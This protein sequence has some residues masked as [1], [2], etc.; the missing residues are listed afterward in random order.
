[1]GIVL[2]V[3]KPPHQPE[4][5]LIAALPPEA[6][7][8]IDAEPRLVS[9]RYDMLLV[10][11]RGLVVR[12]HVSGDYHGVPWAGFSLDAHLRRHSRHAVLTLWLDSRRPVELAINMGLASNIAAVA[13]VLRLHPDV[14]VDDVVL[15]DGAAAGGLVAPAPAQ[16]P[17][18]A[19]RAINLF[20]EAEG[21]TV[22]IENP[23]FDPLHPDAGQISRWTR[24]RQVLPVAA[25]VGFLIVAGVVGGLASM[26]V[27][28]DENPVVGPAPV[29]TSEAATFD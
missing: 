11:S 13:P 12:D 26:L 1:M 22:M 2:T 14:A 23:E 29:I 18:P 20:N 21:D 4:P 15:D 24:S 16:P 6:G 9:P 5:N 25:A 3:L 27:G 17:I 28:G 10:T 7:R 8:V 19:P